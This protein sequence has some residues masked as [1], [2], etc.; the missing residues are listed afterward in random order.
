MK[1]L[2]DRKKTLMISSL[3]I[4]GEP[5]ISYSTYVLEKDKIYIYISKTAP[6]YENIEKNKK[7]DVMILDDENESA[8]LFARKRVSFKCIAEKL[9][10]DYDKVIDLFKVIH[11]NNIINTLEKLDFDIFELTILNGRLVK[12]F[13]RAYNIMPNNGDF[14]IE[15][16]TDK[17]VKGHK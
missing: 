16:L 7:I 1:D 8:S 11:G 2:L 9:N 14:I 4:H 15:Q 10:K 5:S 13:G 3:D 12:G 17:D 6:H